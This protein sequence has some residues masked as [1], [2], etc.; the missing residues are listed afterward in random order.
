MGF[1]FCRTGWGGL[2]GPGIVGV[3]L[4]VVFFVALVCV[5][6]LCAEWLVRQLRG[7]REASASVGDPLE[8]ARHR[9][10]AGEITAAEFDEIRER[11]AS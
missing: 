2:G 1:P 8:L 6:G 4:N 5:A 7:R 9:L 10:A 11:L 3:I